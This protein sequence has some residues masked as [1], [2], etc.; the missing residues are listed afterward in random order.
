MDF[1]VSVHTDK[2]LVK[3]TNQDSLCV[4]TA[5]TPAGNVALGAVCDG[6]GGLS[7]GEL[8]SASV[9]IALSEWFDRKLPELLQDNFDQKKIIAH[10]E[11]VISNRHMGLNEYGKQRS[12]KIGTT[13]T[14][15]LFIYDHYYLAQVGDSRAYSINSDLKRLTE[16]QTLVAREL[17]LGNITVEEARKYPRRNV[18]LQC[19]GASEK[20]DIAFSSGAIRENTVYMICSDGL[21][22]EITEEELFDALHPKKISTSEQFKTV[23]SEM[24]ELVKQRNEQ[25]NISVVGIK[26][27]PDAGVAG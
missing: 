13:L 21:T 5:S 18:L 12:I 24:V 11:D 15:M 17:A 22:H 8:A 27:L 23:L 20:I 25:D 14:L 19:L 2:G 4:K 3:P 1:L 16:D 26:A 10:L 7:H 9:I 6:M